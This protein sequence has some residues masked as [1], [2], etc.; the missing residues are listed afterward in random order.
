M[1]SRRETVASNT[2]RPHRG[3]YRR[4]NRPRAGASTRLFACL[5]WL[6]LRD[7]T[8]IYSRLPRRFGG[9]RPPGRIADYGRVGPARGPRPITSGYRGEQRRVVPSRAWDKYL[10]SVFR[11]ISIGIYRRT[12]A[13]VASCA[14]VHVN[15]RTSVPLGERAQGGERPR[16]T[17]NE[18]KGV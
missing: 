14:R 5:A 12:P 2:S 1:G 6:C 10:G 3:G 8:W 15:I 4:R 11:L 13:R 18:R 7:Q 17:R 16:Y 9:G